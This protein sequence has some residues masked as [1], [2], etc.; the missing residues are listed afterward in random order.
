[1]TK[2][3]VDWHRAYD[4]DPTMQARLA[5]VQLRI[6]EALDRAPAGEV[7]V[8][9]ACAGDG[10]D[11]LGVLER[12]PRARDVR[13]RLVELDPVLADRGRQRAAALGLTGVEFRE[14]DA[15]EA[16]SFEGAVPADLVL[17]CGVFGN[18]SDDDLR[19]TVAHS[20]E[21]C[22]PGATVIW[23]RGRFEPDLTP[24]IRAWFER[25]GFREL[26]FTTIAG[27]TK[28]VGSGRL[29]IHP[30]P[31]RAS[32][33]LFTFLPERERP[34]RRASSRPN[35]PPAKSRASPRGSARS[36]RSGRNRGRAGG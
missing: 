29:T 8:I 22:A 30:R 1:M 32:A 25:A 17:L 34:S 31:L 26:S 7:R 33:R 21:L 24:T 10:R 12:H 18:V 19:N 35:R 23:T 27:S 2:E 15:G 28:S 4:T 36:S 6:G 20:V 3:W 13:A 16:R 9:S 11:L 5:E 14:A